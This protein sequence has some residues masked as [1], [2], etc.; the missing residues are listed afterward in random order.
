[1][2]KV[3]ISSNC[4]EYIDTEQELEAKQLEKDK[5]LIIDNLLLENATL[6][7]Q[8]QDLQNMVDTLILKEVMV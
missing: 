6:K 7:Q 5:D 8:L 4:V 3:H 1:M 2:K